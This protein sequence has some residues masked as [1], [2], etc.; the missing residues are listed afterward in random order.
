M[1]FLDLL[2]AEWNRELNHPHYL[3]FCLYFFEKLAPLAEIKFVGNIFILYILLVFYKW[4]AMTFVVTKKNY[5]KILT[6]EYTHTYV[7]TES[8]PWYLSL[9]ISAMTNSFW[10]L[11]GYCNKGNIHIPY[12]NIR[13]II[14]WDRIEI[15][16]SCTFLRMHV[17]PV[18]AERAI[19]GTQYKF[20]VSWWLPLATGENLAQTGQW[21]NSQRPF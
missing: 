21:I 12:E 8:K 11:K 20:S 4:P 18:N 7:H 16:F 1:L 17:M 10:L 9:W 13:E 15:Y 14:Q 2:I 6:K 19:T 3:H 5:I